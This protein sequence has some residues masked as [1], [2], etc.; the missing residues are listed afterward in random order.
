MLDFVL[1]LATILEIILCIICVKYL[2]TLEKRVQS[3]SEEVVVFG[4]K[5]LEIVIKVKEILKRTNKIVSIFTNKKAIMTYK[6]IRIT[7]DTIHLI[8]LFRTLDFSKGLKFQTI[9]KIFY[10]Q[11]VKEF[12]K[13][14]IFA[15]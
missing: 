3:L 4:S 2:I 5:I 14:F 15:C 10:S 7:I 11:V 8:V 6:I 9:K 1:I 12:I 13:K